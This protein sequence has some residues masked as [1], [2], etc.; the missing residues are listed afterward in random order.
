MKKID[1]VLAGADTAATGKGVT[2]SKD[3]PQLFAKQHPFFNLA[4]ISQEQQSADSYVKSD[5][6]DKI[7]NFL[8]SPEIKKIVDDAG[9]SFIFDSKPQKMKDGDYY[10]L[11]VLNAKPELTG[12]IITNAT[13]RIDQTENKPVVNMEMNDEGA[14]EWARITG[15]NVGQRCAVVLDG[16]VYSAPVIQEKIP[17][18]QSRISGSANMEEAKLLEI[19]LKAGALPAPVIPI[20]ERIIG[21][22]LGADS[23]SQG[24]NAAVMGFIVVS[25]F[26][27]FYY[28]NGGF[29]AFAGLFFT[30]LISLAVLAAFH[31][32]LT[33]PGIAGVVLSMGMAV[34]SNVL[35][36]E[37]IREELGVGKTLRAAIDSGFEMSFSAIFDS[38]I[39]TLITGVVLYQFGTGP[40][41]GFA[42]T[43]MI[44]IAASL[45]SALVFSRLIFDYFASKGQMIKLG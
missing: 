25:L 27:M 11:H 38:N 41:Q 4:K 42:L 9:V 23:V 5:D 10:L 22:S 7:N 2:N 16:V 26:M 21:P 3:D 30:I 29:V 36:Y 33:L 32:V 44:G 18:G 35:I 24:F 40:V 19:V 20:E 37:R 15:Q 43:L 13:A 14:Q 6:R 28:K 17:G 31:G 8:A 39:T 45:F 12:E 1:Q 34:D